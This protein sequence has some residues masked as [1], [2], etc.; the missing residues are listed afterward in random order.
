MSPLSSYKLL[1]T[2]CYAVAFYLKYGCIF[3][4]FTLFVAIYICGV[5][6]CLYVCRCVLYLP[7]PLK[8]R[9]ECR[10]L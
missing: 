3:M 6:V 9:R 10:V 7:V 5:S 1:V 4:P 2:Y 8:A